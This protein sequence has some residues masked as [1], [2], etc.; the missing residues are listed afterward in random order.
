M[1]LSLTFGLA[2][3]TTRATASPLSN[4]PVKRGA[5]PADIDS[6]CGLNKNLE[7]MDGAQKAF[8]E[9]NIEATAAV[10]MKG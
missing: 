7:N 8:D 9:L 2:G 6:W 1:H 5:D 10:Y 3:L 4:M